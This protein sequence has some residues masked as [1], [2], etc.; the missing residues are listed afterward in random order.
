MKNLLT[1]ILIAL[2]AFVG[3][4][5]FWPSDFMPQPWT[6]ATATTGDAPV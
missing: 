1:L 4:A 2:V 5:L 6:V 3:Y